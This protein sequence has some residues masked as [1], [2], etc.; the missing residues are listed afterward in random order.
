MDQALEGKRRQLLQ[1]VWLPQP[2]DA[3]IDSLLN[4]ISHLQMES[5]RQVIRHFYQF[6]EVLNPEQWQ[7]FYGIISERFPIRGGVCSPI[8]STQMEKD[9]E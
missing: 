7:K 6:K 5:Q 2:K 4:Q 3:R 1:E 9:H 8:R